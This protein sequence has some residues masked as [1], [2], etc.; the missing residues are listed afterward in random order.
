MCPEAA[1]R[2]YLYGAV[3][4][5]Q[6]QLGQSHNLRCAVPAV[7]AV[8]QDWAVVPV[9][10]VDHQQRGLQQ[11]GQMLQPLGALQSRKPA[12][13]TDTDHHILGSPKYA[14]SDVKF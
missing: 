9:H 4:R 5:V 8:H 3:V 6:Q 1:F 7:G 12:A 11:Q 13:H 14:C 10:G 2:L